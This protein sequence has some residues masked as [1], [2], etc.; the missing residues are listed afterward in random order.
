[1]TNNDDMDNRMLTWPECDDMADDMAD[2]EL[3]GNDWA[4]RWHILQ[5]PPVIWL[6][7]AKVAVSSSSELLAVAK[8]AHNFIK[9]HWEN[10]LS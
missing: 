1:M 9:K 7:L 2:N 8:K 6:C 4:M 10:E 3:L 5:M